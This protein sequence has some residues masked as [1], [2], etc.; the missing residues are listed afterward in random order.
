[1]NF[2]VSRVRPDDTKTME[3]VY[4]LLNSQGLRF[5]GSAEETWVI[6]DEDRNTAATGSICGNTLRCIA[7]SSGYTGEG[8]TNILMTRLMEEQYSRGNTHVFLYTKPSSA[9]YF[10]DLGFHEIVRSGEIVFMENKRSGFRSYLQKLR[11]FRTEGPS[12]AIVMNANPFTLG[13]RYLVETAAEQYST[14]H[15]F[16]V[17]EDRS[18]I[19]FEIRKKLV[20]AG[21]AHL[22]N[23]ICHDSG[24]YIISSATFPSYFQKD[25]DAVIRSHAAVDL[26]VFVKIA[27]AIGITARFVGDEPG[28]RTTAVYNEIMKQEL[29]EHGI[30][31]IVLPRRE[32]SYGIISASTVRSLIKEGNTAVLSDYLPQTTLSWLMSEEAV[33]IIENIRSADSVIH[34]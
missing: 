22:K 29:P 31:C 1:M 17:S 11:A 5:D 6:L 8:L 16:I 12:A 4:R 3:S 24:S 33:P 23:V 20:I 14:V 19:P 18:L 2:T 21:T 9:R 25:E 13:H 7:V 27:E 15:L 28:S 30:E 32:N 26:A 10:G 34:E